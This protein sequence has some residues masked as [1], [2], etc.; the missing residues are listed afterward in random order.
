MLKFLKSSDRIDYVL[1][2]KTA[3]NCIEKFYE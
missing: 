2:K 1:D 3:E